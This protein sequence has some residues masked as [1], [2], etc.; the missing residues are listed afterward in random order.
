M[1]QRDITEAYDSSARFYADRCF[2]ELEY[3]PLDRQLLDRFAEITRNQGIVC[4]V[5]CGPGEVANYLFSKGSRVMGID[6]SKNMI[7][8]ARRL[9]H[10]IEYVVGDMLHLQIENGYFAGI[11]SFYAIVNF[12]YAEIQ[13]AF[14]E[15]HRVLS[16]HG[17]L[18]LA[19]HV[20]EKQLLV[21]NFF[22]SGRPLEF[23]YLDED[24]ILGKLKETGFKITQALVRH[25]YDEEYPSKRAYVFAEKAG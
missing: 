20:G 7:D 9:N 4:D 3:K 13:S 11:C 23:H 19:F 12:G 18:L 8:E 16:S 17:L 25:P 14:E 5:G 21:E 15:Y 2:R 10:Q 6:I 22:Q 1:Q 24:I